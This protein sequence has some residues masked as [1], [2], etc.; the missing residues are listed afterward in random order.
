MDS[1]LQQLLEAKPFVGK[2]GSIGVPANRTD[3]ARKHSG[4]HHS[5][6][7]HG[8]EF[9]VPRLPNSLMRGPIGSE[10]ALGLGEHLRARSISGVIHAT[11]LP[12]QEHH[13]SFHTANS[14]LSI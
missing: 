11:V 12:G 4:L 6:V 2:P 9:D 3:W 1:L 8:P 14:T 10:V 13:T 7:E 5:L